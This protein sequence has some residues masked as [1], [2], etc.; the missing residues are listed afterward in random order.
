MRK[1]TEGGRKTFQ[2]PEGCRDTSERFLLHKESIPNPGELEKKGE[3]N[4]GKGKR[5]KKKKNKK[6]EEIG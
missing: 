2:A 3:K 4:K 6:K 1:A 5:E